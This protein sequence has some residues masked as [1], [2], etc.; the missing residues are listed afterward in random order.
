MTSPESILKAIGV[1]AVALAGRW[2]GDFTW[3]QF[4]G[5][6]VILLAAGMSQLPAKW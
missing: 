1:V 5:L 3:P 6:A 2:I 4:I